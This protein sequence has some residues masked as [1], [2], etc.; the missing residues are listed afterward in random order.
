MSFYMPNY[1]QLYGS[2]ELD[3][4]RRDRSTFHLDTLEAMVP[5]L[6]VG[7]RSYLDIG[8]GAGKDVRVVAAEY[9]EIDLLVGI[10]TSASVIKDANLLSQ[11]RL[12]QGELFDPLS[13]DAKAPRVGFFNTD[14]QSLE[15]HMRVGSGFDVIT[16]T[17]VLHLMR[18]DEAVAV[19]QSASELLSEN[20]SLSFAT[21]TTSSGDTR[22]T[23][24]PWGGKS[25][26]KIFKTSD[27]ELHQSDDG[28][29]RY[30]YSARYARRLLQDAGMDVVAP[31]QIVKT[32][33]G[34]VADCEFI[35]ML[36]KKV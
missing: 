13:L 22:R 15:Q 36:A 8:C 11:L 31:E 34:S 35:V 17:S 10:D 16:I 20:G 33:Y 19:L 27:I 14:A 2:R 21:K 12:S 28:L 23:G 30:Y 18:P 26:K 25:A 5:E 7:A 9:P 3:T 24:H 29:Y 1:D 6:L 4:S 32:S